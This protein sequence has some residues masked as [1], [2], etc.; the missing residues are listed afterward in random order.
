MALINCGLWWPWP[1]GPTEIRLRNVVYKYHTV[2][3]FRNLWFVLFSLL[4]RLLWSTLYWP[5]TKRECQKVTPT[6]HKCPWS[7]HWIDLEFKTSDFICEV[8]LHAVENTRK[9]ITCY[10]VSYCR[11]FNL[12]KYHGGRSWHR[13]PF[14]PLTLHSFVLEWPGEPRGWS[15]CIWMMWWSWI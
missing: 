11:E 4:E 8:P 1:G 12:G 9:C 13:A 2:L 15:L 6:W 5:C 14:G 3:V 7:W 10:L